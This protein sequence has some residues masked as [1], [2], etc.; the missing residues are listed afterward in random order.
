MKN[1]FLFTRSLIMDILSRVSMLFP[2]TLLFRV[3]TISFAAFLLKILAEFF[4]VLSTY[5]Y[6]LFFIPIALDCQILNVLLAKQVFF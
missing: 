2:L 5:K 4:K 3:N 1:Q 6:Q